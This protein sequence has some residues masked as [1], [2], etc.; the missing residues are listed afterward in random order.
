MTKLFCDLCGGE[1]KPDAAKAEG[2]QSTDGGASLTKEIN[3]RNTPV[4]VE[5]HIYH[6]QSLETGPNDM[7]INCVMDAGNR[8]DTRPS[9][10]PPPAA[11]ASSK[12][13]KPTFPPNQRIP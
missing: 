6:I 8:M 4:R 5:V 1:I 12:Q 9:A 3:L 10:E 7:C 11:V 13:P 2:W